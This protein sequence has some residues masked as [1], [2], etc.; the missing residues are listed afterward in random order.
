MLLLLGACDNP[1]KLDYPALA[2][3]TGN[4]LFRTDQYTSDGTDFTVGYASGL[5]RS[6]QIRLLWNRCSDP[7]FM[8]YSIFRGTQRIKAFNDADSVA[9]TVP[10]LG[11][12]NEYEFR[13]IAFTKNGMS[14]EDSII[15]STTSLE[16]PS[17]LSYTYQGPTSLKLAWENN[18]TYVTRFVIEKELTDGSIQTFYSTTDFWV[19]TNVMDGGFY[20]YRVKAENSY[21][22]TDFS[23]TF[24][25][26]FQYNLN[27]PVLT[28]L[29][30][31]Y[32]TYNVRLSW[33]DQSSGETAFH[34]YRGTN[35]SDPSYFT[36]IAELADNVET[37]T[38]NSNKVLGYNYYYLVRAYNSLEHSDSNVLMVTISEQNF[39]SFDFDSDNGGFMSDDSSGWNWGSAYNTS[40]HSGSYLWGT[41]LQST[42]Y[43]NYSYFSLYSPATLISPNAQ[44]QFWHKFSMETFFDGGNLQIS[45]D[46]GQNWYTLTPA[47]GYPQ[48]QIYGLGSQPGYSGHDWNWSLASF[49]LSDYAGQTAYLR[50]Q[51]GT[52]G[53]GTGY[54][55][56]IDDVAIGQIGNMKQIALEESW[57]K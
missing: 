36:K 22:E 11:S 45:I 26:N 27:N 30:Q 52:D 19:D 41:N 1:L 39:I 21:E 14:I 29:Q 20:R 7:K 35:N 12:G 43:N 54:G 57:K 50:W 17:D 2:D 24:N 56:F 31:L 6:Q 9:Y 28:N 5:I 34:I 23:N 8:N 10:N 15:L 3:A 51:F 44:L 25:V 53:G 42:Y 37:F 18:A 32:P 16:R 48:N 33:N 46:N 38:D 47:G 4:V 13:V 55:W 49:D 40:A